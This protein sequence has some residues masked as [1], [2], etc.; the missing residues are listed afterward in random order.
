MRKLL[1]FGCLLI[2]TG[3]LCQNTIGVPYITNYSKNVYHA[4]PQA[5][6]IRQD[7]DGVLYFATNDGL[8]SFDGARWQLYPLPNETKVLSLAIGKDKRIYTGSQKEIGYF[9][10]GNCGKL[11]YTSLTDQIPKE[12]QDFSEVWDVFTIENK[13][14]FRANR[15]IYE[16]S[17]GRIRTYKSIDWNFMGYSNGVLLAHDQTAGLVEYR[18]GQWIQVKAGKM[19]VRQ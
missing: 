2:G 11:A 10:A 5:Y 15:N 1:F 14:F 13:V 6:D 3:S 19:I 16:Y 12:K 8:L 17:A 7:S 18:D 9:S 4:G